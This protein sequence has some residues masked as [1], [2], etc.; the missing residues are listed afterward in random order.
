MTRSKE[1]IVALMALA[2]G[3]C[4]LFPPAAMDARQAQISGVLLV[5]LSLWGTGLVPG[6]V[7]STFLFAALILAGLAPPGQV[8]ASFSSSAIWLVV[9]GAVI[10]AA[11]TGTGLGARLGALARPHLSQSHAALIAGL[12]LLGM[13]LGFAMP[14]SLGR[15]AVL[16]PVGMA[17]AD[18][19]GL[20]RGTPG[21]TGV[22]VTIAIGTNM[23]SFAILPSNLPNVILSGV[24]E[25]SLGAEFSYGAYLLLHYPVL[26]L[27]KA[28]AIVGLVLAFFPAKIGAR[29]AAAAPEP[30]DPR[31]QAALVAILLATLALWSTDWLHGINPAW[32]G[33][34]ASLVL[35]VP[36]FGFVPPPAFRAAVDFPTLLFVAGAL[37]LGA[38]VSSSGLGGIIAGAA[39]DTLPFAEGRGFA[40]FMSLSLLAAGTSL[41]TTIAGVPAVLT[42]LA[43]ELAG[44]TGFPQE[45][46]LMTQVV[47]FST[48][49]FPYQVSPLIVAMGLAG[50]STRPLLRVM[51]ALFAV[52]V[53]VLMPLDFL[54][55]KL[56]GA[57]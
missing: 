35:M 18:A 46:V 45:A 2:A 3:A 52:T 24:A 47:G 39:L 49:L 16:V 40:N 43:P 41:F 25:R 42:P 4:I 31:R 54:W 11:V 29:P 55:W 38:V 22:A 1:C 56:L 32:I 5:T 12:M 9:T 14:S 15:A 50:E 37:T 48:V 6:Y 13:A 10:G 30:Q 27:L 33:L 28:A 7:A 23:P 19:L 53:L 44:A 34:G 57:I 21:R 51:L 26:G 20:E 36:Q 17:L 8:F